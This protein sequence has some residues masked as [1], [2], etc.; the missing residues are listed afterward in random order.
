[1]AFSSLLP[2]T[3]LKKNCAN[4][5]KKVCMLGF[6]LYMPNLKCDFALYDFLGKYYNSYLINAFIEFWIVFI[7]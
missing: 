3:G 5:L 6:R 7:Y 2:V 4:N 1:M